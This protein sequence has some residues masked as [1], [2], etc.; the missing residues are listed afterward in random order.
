MNVLAW[1]LSFSVLI[2]LMVKAVD[3]HK[4][5]VCRQEAWLKSTELKTR[6][7]LTEESQ[8]D[9]NIHPRCRLFIKR[10]GENITW[11]RMPALSSHS[12][13]LPLKGKL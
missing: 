4:A 1:L 6:S 13:V 3:F 7:L 11:Q 2:L 5:T 8:K 10:D 12:F 9:Q